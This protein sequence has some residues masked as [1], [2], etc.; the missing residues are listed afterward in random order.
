MHRAFALAEASRSSARAT[1]ERGALDALAAL[2]PH[3]RLALRSD[4]TRDRLAAARALTPLYGIRASGTQRG[5]AWEAVLEQASALSLQERVEARFQWTLSRPDADPEAIATLEEIAP[6]ASP[7]SSVYV[8]LNVRLA[9]VRARRGRMDAARAILSALSTR[10]LGSAVDAYRVAEAWLVVLGQSEGASPEA[11]TAAEDLVAA[12]RALDE[13]LPLARALWLFALGERRRG[14][15]ELAIAACR[16]AHALFTQMDENKIRWSV[17][18]EQATAHYQLGDRDASRACL[19][20][21]IEGVSR[22]GMWDKAAQYLANLAVL[23]TEL[24]AAEARFREARARAWAARAPGVHALTTMNLGLNLHLQARVRD[25]RPLYEEAV[26]HLPSTGH[27]QRGRFAKALLTV[28]L[29]ELGETE[30]A[31]RQVADLRQGPDPDPVEQAILS[32]LD[33]F[34]AQLDGSFRLPP[35]ETARPD[36]TDVT[37]VEQVATEALARCRKHTG[38]A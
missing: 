29:A 32:I 27:P 22:A 25:A 19:T 34:L 35:P 8:H 4:D 14:Q 26:R 30:S 11:R 2:E 1:R 15:P 28:A 10:T 18:T 37:L 21:A 36:H 16:E 17:L 33:A 24:P 20:A 9:I 12:A 7:S 38:H 23:E 3:V 5:E 31:A 13:P 6:Q